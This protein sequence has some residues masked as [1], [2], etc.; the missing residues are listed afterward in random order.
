MDWAGL[1][2]MPRT[3]S[4]LGDQGITFTNSFVATPLCA[5]SRATLLTGRYAHNHGVRDNGGFP[6]VRDRGI[7]AASLAPWLKSAG[8]RT[9]LFGKYENNYPAGEDG[10]IPPGWDH[11]WGVLEDRTAAAFD[12]TV[13]ENSAIVRYLGGAEVYQ[14]DVMA[15]RAVR[16]IRE[17]PSDQPFFAL[18]APSPP[19]APAEPATRHDGLFA[20]RIATRGPAFNED[21][22]SDKPPWV[23][24]L[25]SL[26]AG[27]IAQID[28]LYA[29]RQESL[30]SVDE[31]VG[32]VLEAL[33][34]TNRLGQ[35]YVFFTSDNGVLQGQH[36]LQGGKNSAYE[37]SISVPLLV[38][39][40]GVPSARKV[41][42]LVANIDLLPT[43]LAIAG[44]A[45]PGSVDGVSLVPLLSASPPAETA[46]RREVLIESIGGA[47][48]GAGEEAQAAR[49]PPYDAVRQASPDGE[50]LYVEYLYSR[51][52][53]LYN[54]RTDVAQ[55][56][57]VFGLEGT[58]AAAAER[59]AARLGVLRQCSGASCR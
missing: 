42:H 57:S 35:T 55:L 2:S 48:G 27:Q 23:R 13:N 18:I 45:I 41:A 43:F 51:D 39:G 4:Q 32:K 7:E 53:E 19:H 49:V 16:F 15:D 46:W 30:Q 17:A 36:R 34:S 6:D 40:P 37:E 38:R 59:L 10:Y 1:G 11:W 50:Y 56:R 52:R 44:A 3:L 24:N 25:R 22:V 31:L 54:M 14:T 47:G 21:D 5:P 12:Y 8:Y 28:A 26:T 20:G 9:A 29:R 33:Q 58:D